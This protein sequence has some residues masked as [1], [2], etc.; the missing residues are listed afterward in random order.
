MV[1][2][3]SQV[4][5]VEDDAKVTIGTSG[6]TGTEKP[7]ITGSVF[8]G[9][10]GLQTHGYSALVR[11]DS[12]VTVQGDS[13][14]TGNVYGGGEIAS[15]G[16]F[17]VVGGLP[18]KP[19]GGGTCTVVVKDNAVTGD[20]YGS[21]KGVTPNY[22]ESGDNRSM[23]MQLYDNRPKE[24]NGTEKAEHMYWDYYE[25][26][27]LEYAG[28]KFVWVYYTTKDDYLA[29]IPTLGLAS[30]THVTIDGSS[31]INGSVYG[32]GQRGITLGGV[33]VNINGGTV[34]QDVYGGGALANS[35]SSHWHEGHRTKYVELDELYKGIPLNGYYTKSGDDTY[36]LINDGS[37]ADGDQLKKYYAIFKTNVNLKG[38]TVNHNVYGGG[39]G[40][41]AKAAVG[42][43]GSEGY[44]A[45]EDA[46]EA[47]VYGDV[48]VVLNKPTSTTTGEGESATTTTTYG[49]CEVKG[50]IFGC[51]NLNGS[52]QAGV[53]VHVYKTVKKNDSGAEVTKAKGAYEVTAVYGGGNLAAYYPDDATIRE[54]ATAYVT[55]DGCELTSIGSVYGGGNAASVPATEVVVNG[56]YEIDEVFGGGNGKDRVS[57]DGTTY[58]DNPGANVGYRAYPDAENKAYDTKQNR[59]NNY[60]YGPGTAHATIHGGTVHKVYGGS[61][62][63]GNV[64]VESRTTLDDQGCDFTVT[65]AYG[66]G[67]NAEMDGDAVLEIGCI[68]GLGKAYGGASNAD[69]NGNVVLNITNGTYGRVFGGN[70]LGGNITGSITVNIEETGC[71]PI[72]IGELYGGGNQ[73][74]YSIYGYKKVTE[75]VTETNKETG[76]TTTKEVQVWRPRESSTDSPEGVELSIPDPL[77][78]SPQV[79]VKSFTSIGTVY[80]GGYGGPATM[81]GSPEVNIN[82]FEGKFAETYN[83]DDN[84]IEDNARIVGSTVTSVAS[85][86]GYGSGYPI[87]SHAKGAIGAINNVFGGGN[88][89]AV[90]GTPHVNIGTLT[91]EVITLASKKIEDS[92]GK[93]PT[94]EGWIPSYQL[95]TVKGVDI[96]GNVY[97]AGNNAPVTGDTEVVIGKNNDVKTYSF[98]S[99]NAAS[100][101]TAWSSGLAQTTGATET[102]SDKEYAEVVILTNGKY[103]EYIGKKFYVD[104]EGS[105]RLQLF[106]EDKHATSLWV[107]IEP[108]ELKTYNFTSYGA[109]TGVGGQEHMQIQ[110]LTNPG[111]TSWVGKT[112]YVPVS[113]K[114]AGT[115]RTQL[116]KADGTAIDVWVE[117]TE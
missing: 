38:G 68:N 76:E 58:V 27:P 57:Y 53:D 67:N 71:R 55:I 101:G 46:I 104:P 102:I 100:D 80:G 56:T 4:G 91:G 112:F 117:I 23:S 114:T 34:S 28:P 78:K 43:P 6:E 85:Y 99:Y 40:Q 20:V 35:N 7:K 42:T 14:V 32:G 66:G 90:I 17:K 74:G 13:K 49:D 69:V 84:V 52:P 21:C 48:S 47:K 24:A 1:V 75:T 29:F 94:D 41:L 25:T 79:N 109:K 45:A 87:P 81:V 96:R 33:D 61:N 97:G 65:D 9:G 103:G 107:D 59:I 15:V 5:R 10:A 83:G 31:A 22:V 88:A 50:T 3:E 77:P 60:G 72:I 64:R 86:P 12:K 51:N 63:K 30:N 37:T 111:E 82:V 44:V 73:A 26:Y 16:R 36:T 8:G 62:T 92:E 113:A 18:S 110:V 95:A 89:A 115:E 2:R 39:L 98:T 19:K 106:D 116:L 54:N 108:F 93:A 70:D 11:G 105:G